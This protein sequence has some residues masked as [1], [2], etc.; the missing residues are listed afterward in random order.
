MRSPVR[1]LVSARRHVDHELAGAGDLAQRVD[2]ERR[3]E[4][5]RERAARLLRQERLPADD[6][7]P[8]ALAD[9]CLPQR[10]L[11]GRHRRCGRC[12]SGS[13]SGRES[14][15][16]RSGRP[17]RSRCPPCRRIERPAPAARAR[18]GPP[19]SAGRGCRGRR[20]SPRARGRRRRRRGRRRPRRGARRCARSNSPAAIAGRVSATSSGG[21]ADLGQLDRSRHCRLLRS[22]AIL[23]PA[24]SG[25]RSAVRSHGDHTTSA[26]MTGA[27]AS[28]APRRASAVRAHPVAQAERP[29]DPRPRRADRQR[30]PRRRR[31]RLRPSRTSAPSSAS[32]RRPR[33]R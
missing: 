2:D 10:L 20:G 7:D 17:G 1:G 18:A 30:R 24:T 23:T 3:R 11:D 31:R 9:A 22:R 25:V 32:R 33:A 13:A 4:D 29:G 19:R 16:R 27:G 28:R 6:A 12:P 14:C 26:T 21:T 5:R 15:R 8:V